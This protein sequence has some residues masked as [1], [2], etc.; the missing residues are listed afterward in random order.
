MR[1]RPYGEAGIHY[2]SAGALGRTI[3]FGRVNA[4]LE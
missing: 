2:G 4:Q 1:K 3:D